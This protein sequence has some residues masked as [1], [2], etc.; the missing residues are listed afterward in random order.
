[1]R[2]HALHDLLQR[3]NRARLEEACGALGACKS[4]PSLAAIYL[5]I[6][7]GMELPAEQVLHIEVCPVCHRLRER[8]EQ[9]VESGQAGHGRP[10]HTAPPAH[11]E[12]A[13]LFRAARLSSERIRA[14]LSGSLRRWAIGGSVAAAACVLLGIILVLAWQPRPA[15]AQTAREAARQ[16]IFAPGIGEPLLSNDAAALQERVVAIEAVQAKRDELLTQAANYMQAGQVTKAQDLLDAICKAWSGLYRRERDIGRWNEAATEVRQCIAYIDHLVPFGEYPPVSWRHVCMLDLGDTLALLGDFD[17]ARSAYEESLAT[18]EVVWL[19][20]FNSQASRVA[21]YASDVGP[22]VY[23]CLRSLAVAHGDVAAA[24]EWH[25]RADA[26]L[27]DYFVGVCRAAGRAIPDDLTP[28]EAFRAMPPEFQHPPTRP[29]EDYL[30]SF[31][32]RYNGW[33]PSPGVIRRLR[34]HLVGEAQLWRVQ[35]DFESA[36]TALTQAEQVPYYFEHDEERTPLHLPL[37]WARVYIA[38]GDFRRAYEQTLAATANLDQPSFDGRP[39][40]TLLRLEVQLVRATV[41]VGADLAH[42]AVGGSPADPGRDVHEASVHE[43]GRQLL[44]QARRSAQTLAA[45]LPEPARENFLRQFRTW[46]ELA[47]A[48]R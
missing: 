33:E 31:R 29:G 38:R 3:W 15:L 2:K 6:V 48:A 14:F 35:G 22:P 16:W 8:I 30:A 32:Q 23:G 13:P 34:E 5:H 45:Y 9:S 25:A 11:R 17:G 40:G 28:F 24:R 46:D 10:Q 19:R 36:A 39:A 43:D 1:M 7:E 41:L 21:A 20:G 42:V 26:A 18:R 27:R 47:K 37:E 12:T 4:G 44:D